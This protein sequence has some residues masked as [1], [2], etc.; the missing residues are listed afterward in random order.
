MICGEY[1]VLEGYPCL[2]AAVDRRLTLELPFTGTKVPLPP[3]VMHTLDALARRDLPLRGFPRLDRS[4]LFDGTKKL[5]LGSSAA[6]VA[7][8]AAAG[9]AQHHGGKL[10]PSTANLDIVFDIALEGH[11]AVAP[12][13]SG[14]DVA[15][16]VYGHVVRCQRQGGSLHTATPSLRMPPHAVIWTGQSVRT[17]RFVESTDALKRSHPMLHRK[18]IEKIA[19]AT[20]HLIEA[21]TAHSPP[22]VVTSVR[23]HHHALTE[24]GNAAEVPIVTRQLCELHALAERAGGACKPSGAG[25]G[26][27]AIAF[28]ERDEHRT[29]FL[30]DLRTTCAKHLDLRLGD[31]SVTVKK[32]AVP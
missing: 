27:V 28:F 22:D 8:T 4:A 2:V 16:A 30:S 20:D 31:S 26:D 14:A 19:E 29:R 6:A 7:A 5:G 9:F 1:A 25:G 10:Q 18:H 24:L 32:K 23:A 15:A 12:K 13:G 21:L 11:R 17:S 3:E